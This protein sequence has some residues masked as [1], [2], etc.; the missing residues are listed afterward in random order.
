M[1]IQE[2]VSERRSELMTVRLT[3]AWMGAVRTLAAREDRKLADMLRLL[4]QD[5]YRTRTGSKE[6]L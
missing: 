5:G 4:I 3:P 2:S 1:E 6:Q